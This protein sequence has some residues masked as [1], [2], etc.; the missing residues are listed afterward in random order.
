MIIQN[1]EN[2]LIICFGLAAILGH[3]FTVF[4]N[5]KGGKGVATSAGVLI[6][7]RVFLLTAKNSG[8]Q[9]RGSSPE[10][11]QARQCLLERRQDRVAPRNQH[12]ARGGRQRRLG[13]PSLSPGR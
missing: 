11:S 8:G 9:T 12:R 3:I 2:V 10:K 7:W 5:F 1:P 13:R 6:D 4:L